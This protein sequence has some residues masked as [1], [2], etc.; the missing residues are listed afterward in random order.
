[1]NEK[2]PEIALSGPLHLAEPVTELEAQQDQ[3]TDPVV[4]WDV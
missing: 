2:D 1:M 3:L 4:T